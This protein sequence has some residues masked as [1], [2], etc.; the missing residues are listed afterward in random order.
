MNSTSNVKRLWATAVAVLG[1]AFLP[2]AWAAPHGAAYT[3]FDAVQGGCLDSPNGI[4]CNN[5]ATKDDVYMS[6]G[7]TAGGLSDG[8]YYFSVLTPGSQN[9][10]FIE[11]ANGNLSDQ[12]LGG[13]VGDLGSGDSETNR[14]FSVTNH[15]V[16]YPDGSCGSTSGTHLTGFDPQGNPI[17]QLMPYDDTDNPGGVYIL[18]VCEVG[19]TSPSECKYDAFR[20]AA[21][22]QSSTVAITACKFNDRNY[23][24]AWDPNGISSSPDEPLIPNWPIV[25]TING[26]T[27]TQNTDDSGCTI[28]TVKPADIVSLKEGSLGSGW[29]Q[30]A[31]NPIDSSSEFTVDS[32]HVVSVINPIADDTTVYFGNFNPLCQVE[33][34]C[35]EAPGLDISKTASNTTTWNITK[36]V[37]K[38][39]VEQIGGSATFNYTVK[40]GYTLSGTVSGTITLSNNSPADI[41][42][43]ALTDTLANCSFTVATPAPGTTFALPVLIVAGGHLDVS[44][45]CDLGT[46]TTNT[47]TVSWTDFGGGSATTHP[48]VPISFIDTC[49]TATDVFGIK[50]SLTTITTN[51]GQVC[52]TAT[53]PT[54]FTYSQTVSVP[55]HGCLLYDNTATFKTNDTGT[56]GSASKEVEVCGPA[57][58]GAL[59]MGFWQNKN[60][61]GIISAANQANL[62][63]W[64][65]GFHPFSDAPSSGLAAYVYNII[66]AATCS[67]TTY[68][69]NAMLRAQDLATSLDVYFSDPSL[70][71]VKIT[72]PSG[73]IGA[74]KIDLFKICQ[75][76]DASGGSATCSGTYEDVSPEFGLTS[77][78]S[79]HACLT[80]LGMLQYQN[81]SDPALDAGKIWYTN[82]KAQQVLAKDAFDAINNGVAFGCP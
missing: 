34:S 15:I 48:P 2:T 71:G 65:R 3:T 7:P 5:Y 69:C 13:T 57:N 60:G 14:I 55:A 12:S 6:G 40:L 54:T 28:F 82:A 27:V 24:G 30:T 49:A 42:A 53:N 66:K 43:T 33:G 39:L 32:S 75:M 37:D 41:N 47:A 79:S 59:T 64:L 56:T 26:N 81:T 50:G 73:P 1:F 51:L 72:A 4:D 11:G 44:Y 74:V 25:A 67:G 20:V 16:T 77:T 8:C 38:T 61:Q 76:I 62:G 78:P 70:G 45:T 17:V 46:V 31:P 9:G 19:A 52:N 58:T 18:A 80:V 63:T 22:A 35:E 23:N 21:S 10:G 68:P 29:T 36:D